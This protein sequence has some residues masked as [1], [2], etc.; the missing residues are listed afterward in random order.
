[1]GIIALI[2]KQ[3]FATSYNVQRRPIFVQ[4]IFSNEPGNLDSPR[5]PLSMLELLFSSIRSILVP[6]E[7]SSYSECDVRRFLFARLV[8]KG[9]NSSSLNLP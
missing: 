7:G 9:V 6:S 8:P 3:T 4:L 1:M 2:E 5:S